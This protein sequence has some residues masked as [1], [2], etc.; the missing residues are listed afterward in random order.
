MRL[1][2]FYRFFAQWRKT[3]KTEAIKIK[4]KSVAASLLKGMFIRK[5]NYIEEEDY[6]TS[7]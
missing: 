7:L 2:G 3:R 4:A 1:G 6:T 5:K